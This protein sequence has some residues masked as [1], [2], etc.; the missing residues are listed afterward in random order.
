MLNKFVH[1][2]E[3]YATK[4]GAHTSVTLHISWTVNIKKKVE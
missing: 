2:K 3:K 1:F 4:G